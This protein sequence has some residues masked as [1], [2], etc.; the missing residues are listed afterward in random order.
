MKINDIAAK[1]KYSLQHLVPASVIQARLHRRVIMQFADKIG[2]VYFG[3]VDQRNDEHKL[4]RG[5][6]L[7]ANHRDNHY[8]IGTYEGY[9]VTLVERRDTIRFPGKSTKTHNWIIM[10]FDLHTRADLPHVFVGLHTHNETFYAHLF[11]KFSQLSKVNLEA[12]GVYDRS[13]GHRYAIYTTP[14]QA[15]SVASFIDPPVAKSVGDHFGGLTFEIADG[16]LYM[17]ADD[18]RTT[19][20]LLEKMLKYGI[21]LS[22]TIDFRVK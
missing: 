10:T 13:F 9:D 4:V 21:W 5:L 19:H 15:L 14:D 17:Y 20:V 16:C 8:C 7:S 2:L 3:Y 1:G 11:T 22:Q 18:Q 12:Y 6:T